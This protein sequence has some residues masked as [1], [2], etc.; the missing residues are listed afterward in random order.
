M[1]N[2]LWPVSRLAVTAQRPAP[3]QA[4][5]NFT[6]TYVMITRG[7]MKAQI[8]GPRPQFPICKSVGGAWVFA[9]LK[10]P[11]VML[12]LLLQGLTLEHLWESCDHL[13]LKK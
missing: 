5:S 11:Q 6:V 9:V 10:G 7:L 12:M 1:Q 13:F 3:M 4:F 8:A 2:L